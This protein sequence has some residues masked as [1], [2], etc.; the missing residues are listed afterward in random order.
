MKYK[1]HIVGAVVLSVGIININNKIGLEFNPLYIVGGAVF[2]GLI[3]DIDH[4]KSL[5]GSVIQPVSNIIKETIGH[6]TLTHSIL[7]TVIT[8]LF[9]SFFNI[10]IG[11]GIGLGMLSHIILDLL[12][13]ET[14]GVAFLYPFYKKK[15]KLL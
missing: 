1:A 6:R 8:C 11:V 9:A 13:P 12:T 15:I 2:G 4:P 14:N 3:P 7:F 5:L 10:N